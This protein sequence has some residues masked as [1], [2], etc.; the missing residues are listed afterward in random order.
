MN[1]LLDPTQPEPQESYPALRPRSLAEFVG[2][3]ALVTAVLMS[4]AFLGFTGVGANV[5]DA[6]LGP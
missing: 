2:Q 5:R 1:P 3:R 4:P 6:L